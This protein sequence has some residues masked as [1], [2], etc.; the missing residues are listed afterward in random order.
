M[1]TPGPRSGLFSKI[2]RSVWGAQW[3]RLRELPSHNLISIG[4]KKNNNKSQRQA[5]KN[6]EGCGWVG[7]KQGVR[8]LWAPSSHPSPSITESCARRCCRHVP[9][10]SCAERQ[11][12]A[13]HRWVKPP[14]LSMQ[15]PSGKPSSLLFLGPLAALPTAALRFACTAPRSL[16]GLPRALCIPRPVLVALLTHGSWLPVADHPR[17]AGS[18]GTD[19]CATWPRWEREKG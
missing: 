9:R 18:K 4:F 5:K 8:W 11:Q 14:S 6:H 1:L 3:G 19:G 12:H 15:S 16:A 13:A 10:A 7:V 17:A 2:F